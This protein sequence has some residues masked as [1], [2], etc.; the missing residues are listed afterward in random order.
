MPSS[1]TR[2]RELRS[3]MT[4]Q[5]RRLWLRLKTLRAE[6]FHIRRQAPF[7]GYY[8]DFVCFDRR[9]VIELDGG[10]HG[11]D[12][13]AE[14]DRTRGAVLK[15]EGFEILRFWNTQVHENIDGVMYNIRLAL[16]GASPTRPL[17]GHPPHKGEGE[18]LRDV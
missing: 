7:R 18:G 9:V 17:R 2:A 11:E 3:T 15:R 8:L 16:A 6:G 12:P 4:L 5:E 14:H 13:Q 10:V 1:T